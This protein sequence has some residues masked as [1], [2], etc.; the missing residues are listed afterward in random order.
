MAPSNPTTPTTPTHPA[1]TRWPTSTMGELE[2]IASSPHRGVSR[3]STAH[4]QALGATAERAPGEV[5][6]ARAEEDGQ[7]PTIVAPPPLSEGRKWALLAI[8]SMAQFLDVVLVS[9]MCECFGIEICR[10]SRKKSALTDN[11]RTFSLP[12]R[13]QSSRRT[14]SPRILDS[15]SARGCGSSV[16]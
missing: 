8:F 12:L 1:L 9:S 15:R 13:S 10:T 16:S 14:R 3:T 7:D 2:R 11:Y 6:F 4:G 5:D